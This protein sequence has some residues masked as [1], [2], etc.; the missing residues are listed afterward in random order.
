MTDTTLQLA[1]ERFRAI[2]KANICLDE[3]TVLAGVNASGKSTLAHLFHSLINLNAV[4]PTSL[5][6]YFWDKLSRMIDAVEELKWQI[7]HPG[8]I[9]S[10]IARYNEHIFQPQLHVKSFETLLQEFDRFQA[11][12]LDLCQSRTSSDDVRRAYSAFVRELKSDF[13]SAFKDLEQPDPAQI[14]ALISTKVREVLEEYVEARTSRS[15][16]AFL[17]GDSRSRFLLLENGKISLAEGGSVVY[18]TDFGSSD[19]MV[20]SPL[21]PLYGVTRSVYIE[22]PWMSM[23]IVREGGLLDLHDGFPALKRAGRESEES[24]FS[25]LS[26]RLE[27]VEK[28]MDAL[29]RIFAVATSDFKWMYRRNDGKS[30]D[31]EACATGIRSLAILNAYYQWGILDS[32]T[33]LIVDEPEAHLH[34]QWIVE[35]AKIL[36]KLVKKLNVRLLIT[37]H[38]PYMIRALRNVSAAELTQ[39]KIAF[40][41]AEQDKD[42]Q[43]SYRATGTDIAPIFKAF[44]VALDEIASYQED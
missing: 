38:S 7:D 28:K 41:L 35:Y 2:S 27:S 22:S 42:Y 4:Y 23:P 13:E 33:L 1:V 3:I 30:F 36:V 12:S 24:L 40:Y 43:F 6:K 8:E 31:L 29:D 11:E 25:V 17:H 15:Y 21:K 10:S 19:V 20:T 26:G 39:S 14:K 37:T 34:P 16:A 9:R 32:K 5:E 18:A 44:N